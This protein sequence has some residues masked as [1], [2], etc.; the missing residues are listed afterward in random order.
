M[1]EGQIMLRLFIPAYQDASEAVHPG[2]RPLHHPTPGLL[3]RLL[4]HRLCFL[5]TRA[6]MRG[7]PKCLQNIAHLLIV[8]AFV[9]AHA[10]R[11]CCRWLWALDDQ[12]IER[13]SHQFHVVPVGARHRQS[14][15]DAMAVSQQ[16]AL[17][18]AFGAIGGVGA[19]FF[20]R[21]GA[22]CSW[23]HPC[24]ASANRCLAVRRTG[25]PPFARVSR[26]HPLRPTAET[27]HARWTWD[28]TRSGSR[29]PIGSLSGGRKK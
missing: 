25:Q 16:T 7:E 17:D 29:L 28:L 5:T 15:G 9:E 11:L 23:P 6:N 18:P 2:V 22:P 19:G 12:A 21:Q 3:P 27:D 24:L 4:F 8:V 1:Q 26:R 20:P 10:L 14:N 13:R